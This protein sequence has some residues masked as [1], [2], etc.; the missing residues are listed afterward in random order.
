M[1]KFV[2][3]EEVL[4]QTLNYLA[5]KPFHEVNQLIAKIQAEAKEY[6]E[7]PAGE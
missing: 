2:L 5:T 4:A 7:Q 6:Q 3:S 1:K